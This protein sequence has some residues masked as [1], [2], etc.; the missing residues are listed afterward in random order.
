MMSHAILQAPCVLL[1]S[2]TDSFDHEKS[3]ELCGE[4]GQGASQMDIALQLISTAIGCE[5]H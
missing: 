1:A 4:L 5:R 3:L 2:S